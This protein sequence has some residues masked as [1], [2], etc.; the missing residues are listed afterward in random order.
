MIKFLLIISLGGT[1]QFQHSSYDT[2]DECE[3]VRHEYLVQYAKYYLHVGA[4]C[5]RAY[6]GS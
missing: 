3:S 2:I 4:S 6:E 5:V 1:N